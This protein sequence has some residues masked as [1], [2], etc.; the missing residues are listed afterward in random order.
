MPDPKIPAMP[1]E[2]EEAHK[3]IAKLEAFVA[4]VLR[5]GTYKVVLHDEPDRFERTP[6]AHRAAQL[7]GIEKEPTT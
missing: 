3:H 4:D 5:Q 6:L 2:L 7:L 1:P